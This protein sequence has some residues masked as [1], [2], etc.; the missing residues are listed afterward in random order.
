MRAFED[1]LSLAYA[2]HA[3]LLGEV[4]EEEAA[5]ARGGLMAPAR[6]SQADEGKAALG[7]LIHA[8]KQQRNSL[9][10]YCRRNLAAA[11]A[12]GDSCVQQVLTDHCSAQQE[13]LNRR[14][15]F[16]HKVR[17]DQRKFFTRVWHSIKRMGERIWHAVGP[18]GRRIL[19]RA[20]QEALRIAK[21]GGS[22]SL[23]VVKEILIRH[24]VDVGVEE[25]DLLIKKG[26]DRF[27]F[28]QVAL[29]RAAGVQN[30]TEEDL[31]K[32][33]ERLKS[34]TGL[35]LEEKEEEEC[36]PDGSWFQSYW[37][38]TIYPDLIEEGRNCQRG[39]VAV[40]RNCLKAQAVQGVCPLDAVAACEDAYRAIP[41]NDSGGTVNLSP[42]VFHG[43]AEEVMTSL[44]Y[45][46][47]G[48]AVSGSFHYV[49]HDQ[50]NQC[51]I[52]NDA[53]IT[54]TY[55]PA[56]CTMSGQAQMT[57][58]YE[59]K[60]C[61]S[62][63]GS[64]PNSPAACPVTKAGSTSWEA[65]LEDGVLSGGIGGASCEPGCIGFRGEP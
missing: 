27:L 50:V 21:S 8:T 2:S 65:T 1:A 63:C 60:I 28:G 62:V 9:D 46:S 18:V 34:E 61:V 23:S 64:G 20:G 38:E 56:T 35:V 58:L 7:S 36:P 3:I 51:T 45:P 10:D 6:G 57:V 17:G 26:I 25:L 42:D 11:K 54:G 29:A 48:G 30:C 12:E 47:A 31:E 24:A 19:R 41:A 37:D 39:A 43:G 5:R 44:T 49:I 33:K 13:K 55:D 59:G 40:Y 32:A 22:L 52:T 53:A 14:I 4:D 16:L 15:G